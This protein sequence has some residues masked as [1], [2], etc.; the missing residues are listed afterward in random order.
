ML[1][2]ITNSKN[3][4]EACFIVLNDRIIKNIFY[5]FHLLA[6]MFCPHVFVVTNSH[7]YFFKKRIQKNENKFFLHPRI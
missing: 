6:H 1:K 2:T 7:C 5:Q 4:G 3:L